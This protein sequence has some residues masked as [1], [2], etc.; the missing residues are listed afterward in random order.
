MWDVGIHTGRL[1]YEEAIALLTDEVG[2]LRWAAQLEIDG[3]CQSPV[4]KIGYFLGMAEILKMRDEYRE[5]MGEAFTLSD[6]HETLLEVGN[7]PP[8]LMREGLMSTLPRPN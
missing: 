4:Y 1:S 5:R 2:F 7:M 6:F 8:V 3:S